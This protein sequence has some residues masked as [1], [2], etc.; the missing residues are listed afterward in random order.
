[1]AKRAIGEW[2]FLITVLFGLC[3]PLELGA[4]PP[5]KRSCS[6]EFLGLSDAEREIIEL[7]RKLADKSRIQKLGGVMLS[8]ASIP[9]YG[10][11]AVLFGTIFNQYVPLIFYHHPEA[12]ALFPLGHLDERTRNRATVAQSL[13]EKQLVEETQLHR[14]SLFSKYDL[15]DTIPVDFGLKSGLP[16]FDIPVFPTVFLPHSCYTRALV[17]AAIKD[18]SRAQR[19]LILGCGAGAEAVFFAKTTKAE[20]HCVDINSWAVANTHVTARV[21][22]L[23]NKILAWDS[24]LFHTVTLRYDVILA[25]LPLSFPGDQSYPDTNLFDQD[26]VLL[27]RFVSEFRHY[28]FPSGKAFAMTW[29][30]IQAAIPRGV[31]TRRALDFQ[32]EVQQNLSIHE[33]V[34]VDNK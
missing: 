7:S 6:V 27:Q 1:M 16:A 12:Y 5:K 33:L 15:V 32:D 14:L 34:D 9:H 23:E 29:P 30:E 18:A 13:A 24:D 4:R 25:N 31:V 26:G 21:H 19:I 20:V 17:Q 22:G 8:T 2:S 28:L 3:C 11:K 10:N